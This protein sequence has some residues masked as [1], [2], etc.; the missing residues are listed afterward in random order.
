M[1]IPVVIRNPF[2]HFGVFGMEFLRLNHRL[3]S[4]INVKI[5]G[6]CILSLA[7]QIAYLVLQSLF[8]YLNFFPCPKTK[9][10]KNVQ[11]EC[12]L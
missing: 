11:Y 2:Q 7:K 9:K 12:F 6:K 8:Y 1:G 10:K 4:G 3:P 5:A